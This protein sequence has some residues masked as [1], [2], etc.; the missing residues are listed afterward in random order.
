[1]R[2]IPDHKILPFGQEI[3]ALLNKFPRYEGSTQ[4]LAVAPKREVST[5]ALAVAPRR[6]Q[7]KAKRTLDDDDVGRFNNIIRSEIEWV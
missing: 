6:E 7:S 2:K 1:M 5:P 4:A 3:E